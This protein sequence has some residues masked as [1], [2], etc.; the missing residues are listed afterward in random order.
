[1][2]IL[3]VHC[4][5]S[6]LIWHI[7]RLDEYHYCDFYGTR[8]FLDNYLYRIKYMNNARELSDNHTFEFIIKKDK[9]INTLCLTH[10]AHQ[11]HDLS[12]LSFNACIIIYKHPNP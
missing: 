5:I 4:V 7:G 6:A 11:L 9:N 3:C 10:T 8:Y 2:G 1:M 12:F